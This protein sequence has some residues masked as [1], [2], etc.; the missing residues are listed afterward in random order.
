M[1]H[2]RS[3]VTFPA[4]DGTCAAWLYRPEGA[5]GPVPVLVMAHGLSGVKEMRLDAFAERFADAGYAC[6]VFDYRHF[7]ASSGEPRQLL[8]VDTQLVDWRAAIAHARTLPDVDPDRVVAWG[9]SFSGG[10][11]IVLAAEDRRLAAAISQCPFTHGLASALTIPPLVSA[12]VTARALRDAVGALLGRPP[13]MVPACGAPGS[14]AL[15]TAPDCEPGMSALVPPG[16]EVRSDVAARFVLQIIRRYPGRRAQDVACPIL[17]AICE[18][19][20]VAP[21]KQ[22]KRYAAQAPRGEVVLYDVGHFDIYV[23]EAFETNIAHHLDFLARH[24][25]A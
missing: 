1:G 25:P 7:G 6:L 12:K 8:D 20:S 24:V 10:H 21:A 19:D 17:F 3:D 23:G 13:V 11:V 15:M 16:L 5:V 14:T 2:S 9:T 4:G 18:P 22:T